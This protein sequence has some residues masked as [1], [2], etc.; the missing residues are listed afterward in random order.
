MFQERYKK[1]IQKRNE[2]NRRSSQGQTINLLKKATD[3][4]QESFTRSI[5]AFFGFASWVQQVAKDKED[6]KF[7]MNELAIEL[8][9]LEF[10]ILMDCPCQI[11]VPKLTTPKLRLHL[12]PSPRK[13]GLVQRMG[14]EEQI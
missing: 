7:S 9:S 11:P 8:P 6:K 4:L 13:H 5:R 1:R 10:N 3:L 14:L 12:F 2:K